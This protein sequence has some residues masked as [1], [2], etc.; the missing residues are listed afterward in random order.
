MSP[1]NIRFD[2]YISHLKLDSYFVQMKLKSAILTCHSI[3]PVR[4]GEN[5]AGSKLSP[6]KRERE[7][8]NGYKR[9]K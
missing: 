8:F 4:D 6:G 2:N 7:E 5:S 1:P 9:W 3:Q